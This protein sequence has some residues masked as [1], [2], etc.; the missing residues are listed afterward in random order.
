[1]RITKILIALI[2]CLLPSVATACP[3]HQYNQCTSDIPAFRVC[4]C[5]DKIPPPSTSLDPLKI[6]INPM[7]YINPAGIPTQG[8]FMEQVVRDPQK[9][10]ELIG[11]PGQIPYLAVAT[12]M[13][14]SRNAIVARGKPMPELILVSL[15]PWFAEDLMRSIRWTSDYGPLMNF[16]QA[17]QM[18]FNDDTQAIT[19]LNG[20]VFR[21][22]AR[23]DDRALWAHELYHAQQYR[24][25]GVFEFARQWVN[26]SSKSGPVE[27][28]AYRLEADVRSRL[29]GGGG[30]GAP[31]PTGY[32]A[33]PPPIS[34]PSTPALPLP[35]TS[36]GQGG[37][38]ATPVGTC[39]WVGPVGWNC[40]CAF[41]GNLYQGTIR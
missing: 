22:A 18:N 2:L 34:V 14:S 20:V 13:I 6:L 8:D 12:G 33:P 40:V 29:T 28:P 1:M 37:I 31:M 27:A 21:D 26:N 32:T 35:N 3:D 5:L 30:F 39:P 9:A 17:A 11:N 38:C 15:R 36:M 4:A 10:I 7:S 16:F 41:S 25:W 24:A 23:A 19:V